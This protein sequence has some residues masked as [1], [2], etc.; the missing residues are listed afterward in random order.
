MTVSPVIQIE[1]NGR[2]FYFNTASTQDHI[3]MTIAKSADFYECGM[4]DALSSLLAPEDVVFDVG[5]NIGNHSIYFA[6]VVGANVIAFEPVPQSIGL[7]TE[8]ARINELNDKI[9]ILSFG[10]SS[11]R[12]TAN[13]AFPENNLGAARL[14]ADAAGEIE[15]YA[16]DEL[17]E[18]AKLDPT[19]IKID[20]EGMESEVIEGALETIRRA[21]PIIV[22]ECAEVNEYHAVASRL[23][24]LGYTPVDCFNATATYVF[25]SDEHMANPDI[26]QKYLAMRNLQSAK[27]LRDLRRTLQRSIANAAKTNENQKQ[28]AASDQVEVN[29]KEIQ[30]VQDRLAEVMT[31]LSAHRSGFEEHRT[32][33]AVRA[34]RQ[35]ELDGQVQELGLALKGLKTAAEQQETKSARTL[36]HHADQSGRLQKMA[37][38]VDELKAIVEHLETSFAQSAA[39]IE[40]VVATSAD[41]S[42]KIKLLLTPE[43]SDYIDADALKAYG[44]SI[45]DHLVSET[46]RRIVAQSRIVD[47]HL[48]SLQEDVAGIVKNQALMANGIIELKNATV[49]VGVIHSQLNSV[50]WHQKDLET[51]TL[52]R[53]VRLE[54]RI[55]HLQNHRIFRALRRSRRIVRGMAFWQPQKP[56]L[57]ASQKSIPKR[58][59]ELSAGGPSDTGKAQAKVSSQLPVEA[60]HTESPASPPVEITDVPYATRTRGGVRA[61]TKIYSEKPL[62]TVIMTSYNTSE[63]IEAAVRS[64]LEQS[65]NNLELIVVDDC[66]TDNSREALLGLAAADDRMTVY[67]LG[68]NRGTYYCKNFAMTRANGSVFT[69]MDSDDVSDRRRIEKQFDALNKPGIAVST[70]LHERRDGDGNLILVNGKKARIAYISQMFDRQVIEEIGFFDTVRTSADAE[71]MQR[72]ALTYGSRSRGTVAEVLYIAL[73]RDGSLTSDP[74]NSIYT[75]VGASSTPSLSPDR[76]K[77]VDGYEAWHS[78][79]SAKNLRPYTPFPVVRRPFPVSGKLVVDEALRDNKVSAYVATYPP[80]EEKLKN[81]VAQILPQV[82]T[83]YVYLNEYNQIPTF[84]IHP[85]IVVKQS[86]NLPNIKDNGKFYFTADAESGYCFTIDDDINYPQDYIQTLIRKIEFYD[87]SAIVGIHGTIFAKPFVSYL[88]GRTL[89][90][91]KKALR[92]DTIVNQLGTGTVGFH[93]DTVRPSLN[94]FKNT[95]MADVWLA[96]KSK[97]SKIPMVCIERAANWL[98]PMERDEETLFNTFRGKFTTQTELIAEEGEWSESLSADLQTLFASKAEKYGQSYAQ[99]LPGNLDRLASGSYAV[100]R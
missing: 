86:D 74:E 52:N 76:R 29:S 79:L 84:L 61:H 94:N 46:D 55:H 51:R 66:S 23:S 59:Q 97:R 25:F 98:T 37:L 69:F 1:R 80:R 99:L 5:A 8:N 15:L 53:L 56:A 39:E 18:A 82:D 21:K 9:K 27:E 4:L 85:R 28:I 63:H 35:S 47:R 62:I 73:V 3:G 17:E 32:D 60:Q 11:S 30:L 96:I 26:F 38:N 24:D 72:I 93:T 50:T 77:F 36:E 19:L 44:E 71:F 57:E 49:S 40:R 42:E 43:A 92:K 88:D 91:F 34:K 95:G 89:Y 14:K 81:V 45:V 20:V 6:G 2:K 87:R 90:H 83:L 64:I 100:Q 54:K 65:W 16:L 58:L 67:C 33:S 68:K 13:V 75:T 48:M 31:S 41:Q 7:L 10:L 12:G 70:C 22:C 78:H